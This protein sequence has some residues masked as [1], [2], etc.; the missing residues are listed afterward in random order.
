MRGEKV[1][2]GLVMQT[3]G[4]LF[5]S[6]TLILGGRFAICR[7]TPCDDLGSFFLCR[8]TFPFFFFCTNVDIFFALEQSGLRTT[9]IG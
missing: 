7:S 5:F 8:F 6:F 9:D 4:S 2:S 1:T 3:F